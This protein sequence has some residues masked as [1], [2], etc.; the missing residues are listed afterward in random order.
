MKMN[1]CI[2]C[3]HDSWDVDCKGVYLCDEARLV[4]KLVCAISSDAI[5]ADAET[6]RVL[7]KLGPSP[8]R[9]KM[10]R[11]LDEMWQ[12]IHDTACSEYYK[13]VRSVSTK[14]EGK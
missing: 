8:Y 5:T 9:S 2:N 13:T 6:E 7:E 12:E 3:I 10:Q 11:Y 1:E 4:S 14:G